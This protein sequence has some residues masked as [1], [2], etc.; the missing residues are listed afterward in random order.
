MQL[1]FAWGSLRGTFARDFC[2]H[3]DSLLRGLIDKCVWIA[4]KSVL[5]CLSLNLRA[6]LLSSIHN[7]GYDRI[8]ATNEILV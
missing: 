2:L 1:G 8:S 6:R 5:V 7:L 3:V 4:P